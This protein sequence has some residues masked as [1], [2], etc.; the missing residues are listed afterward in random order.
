MSDSLLRRIAAVAARGQ[1]APTLIHGND[2]ARS[3]GHEGAAWLLREQ[4]F[5]AKGKAWV[6]WKAADRIG[7]MMR[8]ASKAP[9]RS[10]VALVG[11]PGKGGCA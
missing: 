8:R 4:R 9:Q 2:H 1:A 10:A 6:G 11:G 5:Q 7:E 3:Q